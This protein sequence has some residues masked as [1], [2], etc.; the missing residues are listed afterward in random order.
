MAKD[1]TPDAWFPSWSEDGTNITVPI[2]SI[3]GLT[4]TEADTATGDIRQVLLKML[5]TLDAAH[6]ALPD[7]DKPTTFSI[8]STVSGAYRE[9]RVRF[10]GTSPTFSPDTEP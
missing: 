1:L 3:T 2:A 5:Q 8:N 6:D 10:N 7:A 9:F 4:D